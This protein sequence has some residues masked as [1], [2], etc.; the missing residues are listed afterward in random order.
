M[1]QRSW[2]NPT[3]WSKK[4]SQVLLKL[5][6]NRTGFCNSVHVN[7]AVF[8]FCVSPMSRQSRLWTAGKA[9]NICK[10][11]SSHMENETRRWEICK[12]SIMLNLYFKFYGWID[13]SCSGPFLAGIHHKEWKKETRRHATNAQKLDMSAGYDTLHLLYYNWIL[14]NKQPK[15]LEPCCALRL[16]RQGSLFLFSTIYQTGALMIFSWRVFQHLKLSSKESG[17]LQ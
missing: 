9:D 6:I 10:L 1:G 17:L 16:H 14:Y 11:D 5:S 15:N 12:T 4:K 8:F 7:A 13:V 2:F 3:F